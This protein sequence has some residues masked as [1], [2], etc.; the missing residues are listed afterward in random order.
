MKDKLL[1]HVEKG[2]LFLCLLLMGFFV[3]QAFSLETYDRLPED[4]SS[5]TG[6]AQKNVQKSEPDTE[7]LTS[8]DFAKIADTLD[9]SIDGQQFQYYNEWMRRYD[10]GKQF[11]NQPRILKPGAPKAQ[12][13]RGLLA[14]YLSDFEG[15]RKT[16]KV[17]RSESKGRKAL[18]R[19]E[20][21]ARQ[22]LFEAMGMARQGSAMPGYD[23]MNPGM[24]DPSYGSTMEAMAMD[25]SMGSG[26]MDPSMMDPSMMDPYMMGS[27]M[28]MDYMQQM[29]EMSMMYGNEAMLEGFG[30]Y[31][32]SGEMMLENL[33]PPTPAAK[34]DRKRR[35]ILPDEMFAEKKDEKEDKDKDEEYIEEFVEGMV[36]RHWVEIVAPFPHAEQIKEYVRALREPAPI[37][38]LRYAMAQVERRELLS[39]QTWSDWHPL[40]LQENMRVIHNAIGYE[41]ED[42]PQ[43]MM[44]GLAMNIPMVQTAYKPFLHVRLE[45][46]REPV[47]AEYTPEE[48]NPV[49]AE[50]KKKQAQRLSRRPTRRRP[51]VKSTQQKEEKEAKTVKNTLQMRRGVPKLEA[52]KKLDAK[53]AKDG[54]TKK[55]SNRYL[56]KDAMIR[57][58]DFSVRPN[59]RYQYRVRVCVFNP[60]YHRSDV[61]AA[62]YANSETL[63]GEWSDPSEEV[64]VEPD[65][66]WFALAKKANTSGRAAVQLL[67]W[68]SEMGEWIA[69]EIDQR[70]G[71]VI[72]LSGKKEPIDIVEW[73]EEE[74]NWRFRRVELPTSYAAEE[75]VLDIGGGRQKEQSGSTTK[76]FDVPFE[77]VTINQ[78]GDLERRD[79]YSD[80]RDE[81][82]QAIVGG[83]EELVTEFNSRG[84]AKGSS[85]REAP[86]APTRLDPIR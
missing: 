39:D 75:I 54:P 27:G 44:N 79:S 17:K 50:M 82:R 66:E 70:P 59:R 3:Y 14:L 56:V 18:A 55:F 6:R 85:K 46:F 28:G 33:Q 61:A 73:D 34:L 15:N 72:G 74:K 76:S 69:T 2:V 64:Y 29:G 31:D 24:E 43:L 22:M 68:S 10:F 38:G 86:A 41:P 42:Y 35:F 80:D 30:G 58:W 83:Y 32:M 52:P 53:K 21:Q 16:R 51:S 40:N 78:Y 71:E 7:G 5:V 19:R 26:M 81:I 57:F 36:G 77:V 60:N 45:E 12:S 63:I 4:F 23:P 84:G 25:P 49:T 11:R 62:E 1:A 65:T 9:E 8:P 20:S 67:H 37:T 48:M 47:R 13:N